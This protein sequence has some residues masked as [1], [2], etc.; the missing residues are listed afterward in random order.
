VGLVSEVKPLKDIIDE[1]VED[2]E[3]ELGRLKYLLD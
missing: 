1:M 3:K 2:A